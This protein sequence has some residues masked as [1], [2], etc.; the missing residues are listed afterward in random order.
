MSDATLSQQIHDLVYEWDYI[1]HQME[2][3]WPIREKVSMALKEATAAFAAQFTQPDAYKYIEAC[4]RF[5]EFLDSEISMDDSEQRLVLQI[6]QVC[7][8]V[9]SRARV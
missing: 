4:N 5:A 6:L 9:S 8:F 1:L 3:D 7:T 2:Q